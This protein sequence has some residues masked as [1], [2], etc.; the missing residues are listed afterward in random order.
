MTSSANREHQPQDAAGRFVELTNIECVA[1]QRVGTPKLLASC[2]PF[3]HP[4][5]SHPHV[6]GPT[7]ELRVERSHVCI[8][9]R[10]GFQCQLCHV[11]LAMSLTSSL[12]AS[13]KPGKGLSVPSSFMGLRA[14]EMYRQ[15]WGHIL[16]MTQI[17][18]P[19]QLAVGLPE[20][21]GDGRRA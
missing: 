13:I 19:T 12:K 18:N 4:Q 15:P 10:F 14:S 7:R 17:S 5:D 2:C 9:S 3:P 16:Y 21:H 1:E 8:A 11:T 6:L 20:K